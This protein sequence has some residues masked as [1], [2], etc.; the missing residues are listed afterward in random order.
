M[1]WQAL[2]AI[3]LDG[4]IG[5]RLTVVVFCCFGFFFNTSCM[6][7]RRKS[8][9]SLT[10]TTTGTDLRSRCNFWIHT[11]DSQSMQYAM[12]LYGILITR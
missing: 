9:R 5:S 6:D 1:C 3:A 8:K 4:I 12:L 7:G 10:L 11:S 2:R